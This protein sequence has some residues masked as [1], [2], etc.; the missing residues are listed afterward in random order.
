VGRVVDMM[1][2]YCMLLKLGRWWVLCDMFING[3]VMDAFINSLV[4]GRGEGREQR[5]GRDGGC[6]ATHLSITLSTVF[7]WEGLL[8][9]LVGLRWLSCMDWTKNK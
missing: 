8:M 1:G 4:V 3:L 5:S 2:V 9:L 7:L 6:C